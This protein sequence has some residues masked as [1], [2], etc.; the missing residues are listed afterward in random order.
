ME[1]ISTS[2]TSPPTPPSGSRL[3]LPSTCHPVVRRV[4]SVRG[5]KV[6][7][8]VVGYTEGRVVMVDLYPEP[9]NLSRGYTSVTSLR[10]GETVLSCASSWSSL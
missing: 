5:E 10:T 4:S 1:G 3:D 2:L 7:G 6:G 8:G 9:K